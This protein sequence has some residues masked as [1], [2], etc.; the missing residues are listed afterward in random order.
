MVHRTL[1]RSFACLCFCSTVIAAAESSVAVRFYPGRAL[2]S[3]EMDSLRGLN[4]ALLQNAAIV[5]GSDGAV[6]LDRIEIDL[7]AADAAL[8]THRLDAADLERAAK[9]G[10]ALQQA[11]LL[12]QYAFQF[13]PELLFGAGVTLSD[14]ARLAPGTALLIGHRFLAFTGAPQRV[15][16]RVFGHRDGGAAVEMEGSLPIET[17][18]SKVAYHFPLA[19]R[20]YVGA[21]QAMH[22]HHRWVVPEEFALDIARLGEGG[23]THRGD[24]G[25]MSDYYAYGQEVLAAADGVVVS[26]ESS[27]PES[28]ALLRQSG[29]AGEAYTKRI[30]EMQAALLA[31][32]FLY[33]A[34]NHVVIEHAGGEFSFYGH[35]KQ[36]SVLVH[37]GDRVRQGAPIARVGNSGNTTE[38]HLHFHVTDGADPILSAGIPVRFDNIEIFLSDGP[39]AIQSGDI[40]ETR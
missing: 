17:E 29:E 15:R 22:H 4:G 20:W 13:R 5:N 8:Q 3:Y 40:V 14:G 19:G 35:L 32:G 36:G 21:G 38:P 18:P 11:G 34:G 2:R 12:S 39:R 6:T 27:I 30:M 31:K 9:K 1:I 16:L 37:K 25:R 23:V 28:A 10:A 33:A 24:G 7:I 26:T